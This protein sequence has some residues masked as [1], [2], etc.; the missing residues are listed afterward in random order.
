MPLGIIDAAHIFTALTDPLMSYLQ[1]EGARS[2]IYIDDLLS[3]CQGFEAALLQDKF[4]Q[5]FFLRGGWVFKPSKSSG[6]PSQ[7]VKYLGLIV[8]SARMQFEIPQEKLDY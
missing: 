1:V 7:R 5:E 4:I 6:P 2:N 3:L 8:D